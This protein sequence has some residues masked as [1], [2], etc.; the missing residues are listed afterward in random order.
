[1]GE[2]ENKH[3]QTYVAHYSSPVNE[4]PTKGFF[5]FD[6]EHRASSKLNARDARIRMLELY[7]KDAVSWVID[8]VRIK[9]KSDG[10]SSM[11]MELDFR[12]PKKPKRKRRR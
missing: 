2:T 6:S 5:E 11:Q 7:G 4:A 8:E 9:K 3:V 1:M 10:V 12:D